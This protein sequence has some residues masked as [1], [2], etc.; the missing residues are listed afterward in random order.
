MDA[1]LWIGGTVLGLLV[2]WLCAGLLGKIY[3]VGYSR[4]LRF[5]QDKAQIQLTYTQNKHAETRQIMPEPT[6][7]RTPLLVDTAGNVRDTNNL[8]SYDMNRVWNMSPELERR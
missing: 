8:R 4:V 5:Q 3:D 7:G 6:T 2:L 1:F